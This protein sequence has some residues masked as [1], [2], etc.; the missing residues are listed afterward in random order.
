MLNVEKIQLKYGNIPVIHDVTF[1]VEKGE[2]VALVGGN[3]N[4]KSSI[5]RGVAGLLT[6]SLGTVSFE[7]RDITKTQA[8]DIVS[9]GISLVPE[10][11]RLFPS[12]SVYK[13]LRLG[14][15]LT[16]DGKEIEKRMDYVYSIF[17]TLKERKDQRASTLSG[18]E[19]QMVA[20][21]RGLMSQPKL[22]LLDEP[23]WGIAPKLVDKIFEV[24]REIRNNGVTILLVE[25]DVQEAL[26]ACDRAYVIQ[27][28]RVVMEGTGRDVLNSELIQKAFLGL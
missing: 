21:G 2:I 9:L 3:G 8:F 5:L 4:G 24:I 18:G 19:Q 17:P 26:E 15:Y 6:P 14:A 16:D 22:L 10:G 13:N 7:G 27:T 11:R 28:G 23:S 25:Q 1:R 12:L 20:I